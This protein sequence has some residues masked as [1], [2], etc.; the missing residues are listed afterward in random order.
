M[1]PSKY[2]QAIYDFV[3]NGTGHAVVQARAG[4][5]KTSTI[6]GICNLLPASAK[7]LVVAF[8]KHIATELAGRVPSHVEARTLH[9]IGFGICKKVGARIDTEKQDKALRSEFGRIVGADTTGKLDSETYLRYVRVASPAGKLVSLAKLSGYG[10][11]LPAATEADLLALADR[12]NAEFPPNGDG[13]LVVPLALSVLNATLDDSGS[14]DFDDMIVLPVKYGAPFPQYDYV[15]VD[16]S[17][18]LNRV[19]AAFVRNLLK[20]TTGRAIFL[21]DPAQCVIEGTV[22]SGYTKD[23]ILNNAFAGGVV[24]A[25]CGAGR[26][27]AATVSDFVKTPVANLP[28]FKITTQSGKTVTATATHIFFA[29]YENEHNDATTYYVYLMLKKG[30]GYRI[31]IAKGYRN[32]RDGVVRGYMARMNQ[33]HGDRLWILRT[34]ATVAEARYFEIL[35][36]VQYGIPTCLFPTR[37]AALNGALTEKLAEKLF[38]TVDT[39]ANAK[40]LLRSLDMHHQ[41]PHHVPKCMTRDRRRNFNLTAFADARS[42]TCI[43]HR[44]AVS[45]SSQAD[46]VELRKFG[47]TTRKAKGAAGWLVASYTTSLG[48]I[49][50]TLDAVRMA[51]PGVNF[52]EKAK[53]TEGAALPNCPASHI[54]VGMTTF[55]QDGDKIV[56]DIVVSVERSLYTGNVYDVNVPELH[57]YIAGGLVSHNAIYAFAGADSESVQNIIESFAATLLPLSICY[58]CPRA[59]IREAQKIVPDI[60]AADGAEEG[61]VRAVDG[62]EFDGSAQDGDWVLCRTTAPLVSNA[63][64]FLR[65]GRKATVHGRDIGA[66]LT[67]LAERIAHLH[68]SESFTSSVAAWDAVEQERLTKRRANAQA[69]ANHEDRVATLVT[70]STGGDTLD[71]FK[72]AVKSLFS[73]DVKGVTFATIHRSK[74]LEVD[75][76]FILRPDLLPH[77]A[78]EQEWQIVQESNLRYVAITRAKR[79]LV[80]VR[81]PKKEKTAAC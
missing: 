74:G 5:G 32:R 36:S 23:M 21:A 25:A 66:N 10:S 17:Q 37:Q 12:H 7:V 69:V 26:T 30:V 6:V 77:P 76:V 60:E 57:N 68:P 19:Q 63:L 79:E 64:K 16:E 22:L 59:V 11:I 55:V 8:N 31:G 9:S 49:R 56:K 51:L 71:S 72:A 62:D 81:P 33:E 48:S 27:T 1:T 24:R 28:V 58:R 18:D 38:T 34:A 35:L 20:P 29:G 45:G 42:E 73:D 15:L 13:A 2:Q 47:I 75:R 65:E 53:L 44:Y 39:K 54:R 52:I 61:I 4:S 78:A 70:L 80:Y 67:K 41:Y 3:Q 43:M 50:K 40:R 46:A 14:A